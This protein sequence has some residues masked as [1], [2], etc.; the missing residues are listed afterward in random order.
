MAKPI[1]ITDD[2]FQSEVIESDKPTL[3]DFWATWCGP[4]RAVAPV[5]EALAN[6]YEGQLKVG[7][8]DID[9]HQLV[10]QQFGIRSIPTLLLFKD[11]KVVE[12]I[13]GA[14]PR[15]KIEAKITP[16]LVAQAV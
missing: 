5:V 2:N 8:M 6:D 7:K 3:I 16:H 9:H 10:P 13:V 11:G 1:E 12:T 4:C 14:A 15:P